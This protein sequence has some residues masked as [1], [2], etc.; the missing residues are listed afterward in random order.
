MSTFA[1]LLLMVRPHWTKVLS[2]SVTAVVRLSTSLQI[3][4]MSSAYSRIHTSS[5]ASG[6][7]LCINWPSSLYAIFTLSCRSCGSNCRTM[8][9]MHEYTCAIDVTQH[10]H[11]FIHSRRM[12]GRQ[13]GQLAVDS[14][15][16][17]CT[18]K[19]W[20]WQLGNF[21]QAQLVQMHV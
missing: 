14:A 6:C 4:E 16:M 17:A 20:D 21:I 18:S 2:M 15:I 10:S 1:C 9:S 13:Q 5:S 8:M 12:L 7:L 11:S 19:M 3:R